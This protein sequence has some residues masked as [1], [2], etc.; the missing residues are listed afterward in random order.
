MNEVTWAMCAI[1][2]DFDV[3]NFQV[4]GAL[5]YHL[6]CLTPYT[7]SLAMVIN[8]LLIELSAGHCFVHCGFR[9]CVP[10]LRVHQGEGQS[11]CGGGE[12]YLLWL[13]EM[14][15]GVQH[16]C[17]MLPVIYNYNIN[18]IL[19]QALQGHPVVQVSTNVH[20]SHLD[21]VFLSKSYRGM[22]GLFKA[23]SRHGTAVSVHINASK[24]TAMAALIAG[25]QREAVLLEGEPLEDV[26][27]FK[28]LGSMFVANAQGTEKIKSTRFAFGSLKFCL[29]LRRGVKY[30]CLQWALSTRRWCDR[31]CSTVAKCG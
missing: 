29:W 20:V 28:Y 13:T 17:S 15:S 10:P 16:G 5:A 27:K 11:K 6:S 30:R 8:N 2:T 3:S 26:D 19:C 7:H 14:R 22:Q 23:V 9:L 1:F 12:G 21:I 18:W 4:I 31:F 25:E 24:T